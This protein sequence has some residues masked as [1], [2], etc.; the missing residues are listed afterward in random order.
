[1]LL[2]HIFIVLLGIAVA[3]PFQ[4]LVTGDDPLRDREIFFKD[5]QAKDGKIL[6]IV[7]LHQLVHLG[8]EVLYQLDGHGIG[9]AQL[10][11]GDGVAEH[12]LHVL[13]G[14]G[15]FSYRIS[16]VLERWLYL[17]DR[18][19]GEQFF[20]LGLISDASELSKKMYDFIVNIIFYQSNMVQQLRSPD[21]AYGTMLAYLGFGGSVIYLIF[22]Y[23]IMIAFLNNRK[24]NPLFLVLAVLMI[25]GLI[26]SLFGDSMSNP[27]SFALHYIGLGILLKTKKCQIL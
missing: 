24:L 9:H 16:W 26:S 17:I 20:G 27:S 3:A 8:G 4:V 12:F 15:G 13:V 18:P 5:G 21:I 2:E 7:V 25:T 19:I 22:Y 14:G 10:Q 23:K 1:M 11:D 6:V